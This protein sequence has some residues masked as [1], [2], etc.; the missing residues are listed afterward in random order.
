MATRR[1][2]IVS[3]LH[4]KASEL[5]KGENLSLFRKFIQAFYPESSP[6]DF[7]ARDVDVL[8]HIAYSQFAMA[9]KR[10]LQKHHIQI[11]NPRL[12]RK[13][14]WK[15]DHT[16]IQII[17]DDMPFLVDSIT[18]G[19]AVT[20][21]SRIHMMHH[22]ILNVVRDDT[23]N[24]VDVVEAGEGVRE[25]YIYVE[26]SAQSDK[27]VLREI[28]GTIDS[29]LGDVRHAV[30]DWK[31]MLAK[32]DET[33]AS[34]TVNPP[35]LPQDQVDETI[36]FLRWLSADHFTFLGFREYKFKEPTGKFSFSQVRGS[37]LGILRDP[38]RNV[39]RDSQG[40]TPM[41]P[42]IKH[43][44]EQPDPV[45]ITKANVKSTVHRVA[46]LDY[47][48]VK[49]FDA[50]GIAVGE[51]RFIGLFTS[52]AY[53]QFSHD[54]PLLRRKV[55]AV[56]KRAVFRE[57]THA[58]KAFKHI[59]ETFPRDE[60]FQISED[61][62]FD[63][64]MGV[65]QLL[66]RP[67]PKAFLR[68]D[69]FERFVS[70]LVYVPRETYNSNL[71]H[72]VEDILCD[73]F[74]GEI[75]VYYAMLGEESLARWH[76]II[77]TKPG[78]VP[79]VDPEEVNRQI[80]EAAQ[81]WHDRLR[82][83]LVNRH[84]EEEGSKLNYIYKDRFTVAYIEAFSP[85]QA[86]YDV[87]KL[88]ELSGRND[89]RVD[90]YRHLA[91]GD[92]HFRL[93]IHHGQHMVPLS[94]CMPILEN[95]GFKVLGEHS[96]EMADGSGAHI[97]DFSLHRT[98][99]CPFDLSHLKSLVE[100]LVMMVWDESVEDDGF[101]Q[102]VLTSAMSWQEILIL[103]AYGKYLRQLGM[104]YTPDYI[105][106]CMVKNSAIST[107]LVALFKAQFDPANKDKK[108][109]VAAEKISETLTDMLESVNSL[110]EDRILRAYINVIKATLR[111]N[112]YQDGVLEGADERALVFKNPVP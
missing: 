108:T 84:G 73:A 8:L 53:S 16:V 83:E 49:I 55:E 6:D 92:D 59:L 35:P 11:L 72:A 10:K 30:G 96:Y 1:E 22:P 91:D 60:L 26:T 100:D 80:V 37:A 9:R 81:G 4:K 87:A 31:G 23:G 29:I 44:L 54:V 64:A 66:E 98:G 77:R 18:G 105:A 38:N 28:Q 33:V 39:L 90:F 89:M 56:E 24:L 46:H 41:S 21:R 12:M 2:E 63:T 68:P 109:D 86:A 3:E 69:Q 25:S 32:I 40:L 27:T 61:R 52:L 5:Q 15:S 67:R 19:L 76:F 14:G 93:K 48:G 79:K 62:L 42:E 50:E 112:Y 17:N 107:K 85:A 110:D 75:S 104:G 106:D 103:R 43:F 57:R 47:I 97:H 111:T 7:L 20:L 94:D 36:R 101:N 58:K 34:L 102:L 70:A 82:T 88:E 65:I 45:I 51:R 78:S 71:R 99:G 74:N 13:G 95:L